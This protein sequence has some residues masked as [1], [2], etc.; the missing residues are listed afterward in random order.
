[1]PVGLRVRRLANERSN[2][3][4]CRPHPG[5]SPFAK[6]ARGISTVSADGDTS[7][8]A[9]ALTAHTIAWSESRYVV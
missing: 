1:M 6:A 4:H 3:Q 8:R 7:W 5:P 9:G 2:T